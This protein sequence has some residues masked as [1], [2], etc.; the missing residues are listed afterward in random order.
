VPLVACWDGGIETQTTNGERLVLAFSG[1]R[2]EQDV[3]VLRTVG[4][5]LGAYS[6]VA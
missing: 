6:L 3:V 1:L 4:E 2:G 5:Q